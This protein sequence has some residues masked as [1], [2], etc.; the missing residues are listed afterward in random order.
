MLISI[1]VL[2]S[3]RPLLRFHP[4]TGPLPVQ[5][6]LLW[7]IISSPNVLQGLLRGGSTSL[8]PWDHVL[9]LCRLPPQGSFLPQT[10]VGYSHDYGLIQKLG[11]TNQH[12]KISV[13]PST[14][15]TIHRHQSQLSEWECSYHN[16]GSSI[17]PWSSESWF[18]LSL[19][20][21]HYIQ[22]LGHMAAA[23]L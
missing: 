20:A 9:S 17:C 3:H 18:A 21:K 19:S 22:L 14:E 23:H 12:P 10:F 2:P 4:R 16:I 7:V 8:F 13:N 5:S 1:F 6:T 15:I 11:P